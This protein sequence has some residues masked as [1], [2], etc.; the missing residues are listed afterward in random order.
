MI[1]IAML[2]QICTAPGQTFAISA[3]TPSLR[4]SLGL[5]DAQLAAAYMLGTFAAAF[6]LLL[7][8]PLADRIGNRATMLGSVVGL[9]LACW[10]TSLVGGVVSLFFAFLLL[11]F[12]GQ[13]ALSLLSQNTAAMWFHSKLGR[14]SAGMSVGMAG[15][16]AMIPGG[17]I[18]TIE[19]LGWRATYRLLGVIVAV[20]MLPL[21]L[22]VYRNH[23]RDV[24]QH[25]DGVIPLDER[26][27]HRQLE[28]ADGRADNHL[29]AQQ[30]TGAAGAKSS[31]LESSASESLERE[32]SE[33]GRRPVDM[34][35]LPSMPF[36]EAIRH[37]SYW[38]V[39]ISM[40][41]WALTGTG[42]VFYLL[43]I[44]ALAGV[45][46]DDSAKAFVTIAGCMLVSQLIG[47]PLA[48]RLPLNLLLGVAVS[49]LAVG[50]GRLLTLGG[51]SDLHWFAGFFGAGQGL[52]LVV[53]ATV[54]VRY[55]G[56]EHLG[57]I[58]GTAWSIAVAGSGAGPFVLGWVRDQTGSF[59]AGIATFTI[60]LACLAGLSIFAVD[61]DKSR[62]A[63]GVGEVS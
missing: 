50:M 3:F 62:F 13:G 19:V 46:A 20:V 12:L 37:A 49:L 15:A 1:P 9:T 8:G 32:S 18:A 52:A 21:L 10:Y 7:V 60:A 22:L 47:G 43:D 29:A 11:R 55:F 25:P 34:V 36:P 41:C 28:Q 56:P 17:L 27:Q 38:I 6:P 40:A 59:Y 58:R 53:G 35:S 2:G 39:A 44:S 42:A 45:S 4:E 23:P 63:E 30:D 26:E 16:F 51:V 54:W 31:E 57:K 61:P 33:I 48:D 24:G 5:S 14:V